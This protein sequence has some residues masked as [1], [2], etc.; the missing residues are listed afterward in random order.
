V[1]ANARAHCNTR[2]VAA[3]QL[4]YTAPAGYTGEDEFTIE[5]VDPYGAPLQV[6][7]HVTVR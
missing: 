3:T 1:Q 4:L 7:Y 6:R 2:K 5:R